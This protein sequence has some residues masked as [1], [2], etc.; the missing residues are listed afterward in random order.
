MVSATVNKAK[1]AGVYNEVVEHKGDVT[2][3][4]QRFKTDDESDK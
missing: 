2:V 1:I 3:I 4:L